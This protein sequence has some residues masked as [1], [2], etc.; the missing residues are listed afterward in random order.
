M[1]LIIIDGDGDQA[2]AL[3]ELAD[4]MTEDPRCSLVLPGLEI[5]S[6][7]SAVLVSAWEDVVAD[8]VHAGLVM[9]GWSAKRFD[10]TE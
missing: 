10:S 6:G 7:R 5:Y 2:A 4:E 3:A 8:E 9:R 1:Q